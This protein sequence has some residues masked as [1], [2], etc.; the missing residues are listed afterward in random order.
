MGFLENQAVMTD[1]FDLRWEPRAAGAEACR[2]ETE[3]EEDRRSTEGEGGEG[4]AAVAASGRSTSPEEGDDL[5]DFL[6]EPNEKN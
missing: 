4:E 1:D 3:G 5:L 6:I 2:E